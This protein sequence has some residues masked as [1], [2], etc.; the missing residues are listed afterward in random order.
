MSATG[1]GLFEDDTE[2]A[3]AAGTAVDRPMPEGSAACRGDARPQGARSLTSTIW[4]AAVLI[5][6]GM[7]ALAGLALSMNYR[8]RVETATATVDATT[9]ALAEHAR[10]T[11]ESVDRVLA[12]VAAA[13]ATGDDLALLQ[14][15][16]TQAE[17]L[18]P[19]PAAVFM[20]DGS[21]RIEVH[22]R[23]S[24]A[25]V[26]SDAAGRDYFTVHRDAG[27]AGLYVGA[28]LRSRVTGEWRLTLSR[29]ARGPDGTLRAV[30]VA[31]VQPEHLDAV[32]G[33]A[34]AGPGRTAVL[35]RSDGTVLTLS[36]YSDDPVGRPISRLPR[37]AADR[38]HAGGGLLALARDR[39]RAYR[40]VTPWPI[41]VAFA[42]DER[43]ALAPFERDFRLWLLVV[44]LAFTVIVLITRM[45][46][47][48]TRRLDEQSN[49]LARTAG[50]L[51]RANADLRREMAERSRAEAERL[52]SE[53]RYRQMFMDNR[54]VQM[55]IDPADGTIV[56]VNPAACAF[57]GY[58]RIA[59]TGQRIT[60]INTAEPD[61]LNAEM[62]LAKSRR[63]NFF[64]FRHRLANG[65]LRDVEV[66]A[67]PVRLGDKTY[68]YSIIHDVTERRRAEK[69][70]QS[71]AA[72]VESTHD[73]VI[74]KTPDGTITSWNRAAARMYGYSAEEAVGRPISILAPP[75]RPDETAALLAAVGAGERIEHF[76]TV[77]RRKGGS[78]IDVS[79]TISPICDEDDA[80]VGMSVIA[81]DITGRKRA[82][83]ALRDSEARYRL[84][85]DNATDMITL[86]DADG[87][88][89]YVSP[90]SER[91]LGY[92]PDALAGR[93]I[94]DLVATGPSANAAPGREPDA[95]AHEPG[96]RITRM[97]HRDG[98][99][100]WVETTSRRI[101][102]AAGSGPGQ[103]IALSRD[104]SERVRFQQDLRDQ[105]D[106]LVL[107]AAQIR[108][109]A[110][111][112]AAARRAA[113]DAN[114]AKSQF[115]AT[116]SHELRTPLNAILGFSEMI[117]DRML[118]P[119]AIDR[120]ADYAA[121]IH[122]SGRHLLDLISDILDIA[123]IESG[124][125]ALSPADVDSATLVE[126]CIRLVRERAAVR[127]LT[128]ETDLPDPPPALWA[129]Q[130]AAKQ[131]LVNVMSN[132]IKF[133][134]AGGAIT[135]EVR[136]A[137]D[138]TDLVI[139]DTGIGI[140]TDQLDRVMRPFEQMD[141]R[142]RRTEGGT[143]L[144]LSL[145]SGLMDLHGG[146][147]RLHSVVGSG[148]TVTLHFP[149]PNA[150]PKQ[151]AAAGRSGAAAS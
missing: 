104:V 39:T 10:L 16:L 1:Q 96:V 76:E 136:P 131:V 26:G 85:A 90:A 65:A 89:L 41:V 114:L 22:S 144:G 49:T 37:F 110:R 57:Y 2:Y 150:A 86:E 27:H 116:M 40:T 95:A 48:Q 46:L 60:S 139:A 88:L 54:A 30:V 148:T 45:Q 77:H 115:L 7:A 97:Q 143:G 31:A 11:F 151:V 149:R 80:V 99:P 29:A 111:H 18:L 25:V 120:Y 5:A 61:R 72:I 79:L 33:F 87:T 121:N 73:A 100:V 83:A 63:R 113:E 55:L 4:I 34:A 145:V 81:R 82:E 21:G 133:T 105:R 106:R 24:A 138:G 50:D 15:L 98:T 47:R 134:P 112:L 14:P 20:I 102:P 140:P 75:D 38:A 128:I 141:N 103:V 93:R 117:R 56:D 17:A 132:A 58:D 92:R 147:L 67:S 32:L 53:T 23:R 6:L 107:Q 8:A 3:G 28:S 36:P 13:A 142:Y 146:T 135:V 124:K 9:A 109:T 70:A 122:A 119:T 130:R 62:E 42:L 137:G 74:G 43:V 84:P 66:Y 59:L 91:L 108:E 94:G 52:D 126:S 12:S 123:K 19:M 64:R 51:N 118:G 78:L 127:G 44:V 35:A 129:D 101:P 125:M 69:A 71:L 68:L